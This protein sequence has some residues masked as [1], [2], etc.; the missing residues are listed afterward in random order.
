MSPS[1]AGMSKLKVILLLNEW[2]TS[3]QQGI[4]G[5]GSAQWWLE[6]S[7]AVAA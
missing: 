3:G 6:R 1:I 2:D 4:G 5:Q 7:R